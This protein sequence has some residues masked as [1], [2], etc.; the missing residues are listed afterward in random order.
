[1]VQLRSIDHGQVAYL[2]VDARRGWS[3]TSFTSGSLPAFPAGPSLITV[4]SNGI[5]SRARYF[6]VSQP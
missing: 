4:F 1:V 6:N 3:D 2:P 5:P